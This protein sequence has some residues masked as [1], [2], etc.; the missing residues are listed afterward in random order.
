MATMSVRGTRFTLD[1]PY[2]NY[3]AA[4]RAA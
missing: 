4:M 2:E 1:G 3:P